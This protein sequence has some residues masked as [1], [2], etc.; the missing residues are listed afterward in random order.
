MTKLSVICLFLNCTQHKLIFVFV[1]ILKILTNIKSNLNRILF[2][3]IKLIF[4]VF[5]PFNKLSYLWLT[6]D[7]VFDLSNKNFIWLSLAMKANND[8]QS[9]KNS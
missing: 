4:F 9:G 6:F 8:Y 7:L 2:D 5:V 3:R 1:N